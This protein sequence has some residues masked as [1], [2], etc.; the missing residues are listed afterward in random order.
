MKASDP[1]TEQFERRPAISPEFWRGRSVLVT[2]ATGLVGGWLVREL[3]DLEAD[4]VALVRDSAP[5]SL[6]S[7]E[8]FGRRASVA[9]GS[10]C[11]YDTVRR[12][13]SDYHV[14]TV[15]HLAAQTLVGPA[16][17]DPVSTLDTN[18]RGTW[19]VLEACR[20]QGVGQVVVAS[21]DK[22]YGANER[23]PYLESHPLQGRYPYDCSKSC[24]DLI[25]S[26]Y[27]ATYRLPVTVARCGNIFGG[28]DLNF[29]R[30]IPDLIRSTLRGE[31]IVIRSDGQFVRD[32]L[33]VRDATEAYLWL[34]EQ[35]AQSPQ[36]AGEAFNFSLELRLTVLDIVHLVLEL[37]GRPD[38]APIIE[39]SASSEIRE[40]YMDCAKARSLGWT[41]ACGLET[42][43]RETIEWYRRRLEPEAISS[44][45]GGYAVKT[46]A[47]G[48]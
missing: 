2:G 7:T 45:D 5:R 6:F 32:F 20:Q 18:I 46:L 43:L 9:Y 40:Q 1:P 47:A 26:M 23:L 37:M 29:S 25:S 36:L 31:R 19:N 27:A 22:A 17:K 3:I 11:D 16:K 24:T 34:S 44:R 38:L 35:T 28:G 4:V 8:G 48:A 30:I 15:F 41:P 13:I 21:S 33:Y 39:N 12:T 10:I 42:G 14:Q